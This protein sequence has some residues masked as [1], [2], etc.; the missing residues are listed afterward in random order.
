MNTD[1]M[2]RCEALHLR[3]LILL[4]SAFS[5]H[6]VSNEIVNMSRLVPLVLVYTTHR[7]FARVDGACSDYGARLRIE[8]QCVAFEN[9]RGGELRT[10]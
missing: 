1:F 9:E 4:V 3:S 10:K 5:Y 6:I 2:P 8:A 7:Y